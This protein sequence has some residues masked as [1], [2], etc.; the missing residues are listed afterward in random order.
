MLNWLCLLLLLIAAV[1][2]KN[3]QIVRQRRNNFISWYDGWSLVADSREANWCDPPP[4]IWSRGKLLLVSPWS[5]CGQLSWSV[6]QRSWVMRSVNPGVARRTTLTSYARCHAAN[7]LTFAL[8]ATFFQQSDISYCP[9]PRGWE[10]SRGGAGLSLSGGQLA[11]P[12]AI[13]TIVGGRDAS[14][15]C[16]VSYRSCITG[17]EDVADRRASDQRRHNFDPYC[18]H[19]M[20][21]TTS[22]CQQFWRIF[23]W[24]LSTIIIVNKDFIILV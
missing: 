18:S 2:S 14:W 4:Y 21:N 17:A 1:D 3:L 10:K 16:V 9:W 15:T 6:C 12:G 5:L 22:I 7:C 23:Q 24:H 8:S 11:L 13:S 19:S 20:L